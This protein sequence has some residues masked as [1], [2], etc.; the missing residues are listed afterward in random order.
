LDF[1][2]LKILDLTKDVEFSHFPAKN[3]GFYT[4]CSMFLVFTPGEVSQQPPIDLQAP[5]SASHPSCPQG[6]SGWLMDLDNST[7]WGW[8]KGYLCNYIYIFIYRY[9]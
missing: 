5:L 6:S 9:I 7:R 3:H 8:D 2:P 4:S 1:T